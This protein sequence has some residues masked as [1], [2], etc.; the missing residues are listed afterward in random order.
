MSVCRGMVPYAGAFTAYD[1]RPLKSSYPKV[2]CTRSLPLW[3]R[4]AIDGRAIPLNVLVFT[5]E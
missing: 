2:F 3:S 1:S 4:I 5:I